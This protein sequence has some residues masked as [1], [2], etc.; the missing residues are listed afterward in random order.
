MLNASFDSYS[1]SDSSGDEQLTVERQQLSLSDDQ[2]SKEPKHLENRKRA[3]AAQGPPRKK[4]RVE[5]AQ[6]SA[7]PSR[8]PRFTGSEPHPK[9]HV[10]ITDAQERLHTRTPPCE[11]SRPNDPLISSPPPPM[12]SPTRPSLSHNVGSATGSSSVVHAPS[13]P[14]GP[15][16]RLGNAGRPFSQLNV[17]D[18]YGGS[19]RASMYFLPPQLQLKRPNISTED[20][21]SIGCTESGKSSKR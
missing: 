11:Y 3:A 8:A 21:A 2:S 19:K 14:P 16:L 20:L 5:E 9:L 17:T 7:V 13:L 18:S 6:S 12:F 10:E 1:S 15:R 4:S